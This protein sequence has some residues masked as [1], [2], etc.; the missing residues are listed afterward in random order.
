MECNIDAQ[1][2]ALR[3]AGGLAGLTFGLALTTLLVLDVLSGLVVSSAAAGAIFGGAF[4]I[5]EARAGWCVVR[6]LGFHT[7]F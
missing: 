3:L 7:R 2:K 1:G 4:A 5:F 6:A